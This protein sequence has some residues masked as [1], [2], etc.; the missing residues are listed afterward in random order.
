MFGKVGL[1]EYLVPAFKF[2]C[3]M[4]ME[5]IAAPVPEPGTLLNI[6]CRCGNE[7][8]MVWTGE[9]WK[10]QNSATE[11]GY[12]PPPFGSEADGTIAK[13]GVDFLQ[14]KQNRQG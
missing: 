7:H 3:D 10:Y 14:Q 1:A 9:F 4:C 5:T 13:G 2:Q 11:K 6:K 8:K 12:V